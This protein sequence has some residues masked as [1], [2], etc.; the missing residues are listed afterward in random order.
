M[1]NTSL[2]TIFYRITVC[3]LYAIHAKNKQEVILI[4][5]YFSLS[6]IPYEPENLF[7]WW[8]WLDS[9]RK[10]QLRLS[11]LSTTNSLINNLCNMNMEWKFKAGQNFMCKDNNLRK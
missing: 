10:Y 5:S 7:K 1:M 3:S 4:P 9:S 11:G 6:G 8:K 2:S